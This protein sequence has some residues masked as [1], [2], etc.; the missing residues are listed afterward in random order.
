LNKLKEATSATDEIGLSKMP[1]HDEVIN[2][3]VEI[4]KSNDK[5]GMECWKAIYHRKIAEIEC[6]LHTMDTDHEE[7][8]VHHEAVQ[9]LI[10]EIHRPEL[11]LLNVN[12][13][14]HD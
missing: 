12:N 8:I 10:N 11:T 1:N 7:D 13:E 4:R 14:M 3:L 6:R 9:F 5:K 2:E